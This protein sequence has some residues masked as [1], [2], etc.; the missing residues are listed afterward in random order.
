MGK[1]NKK[2]KLNRSID[3]ILSY[4]ISRN[5]KAGDKLPSE[6]Q[7]AA[8]AGVSRVSIREGMRGLKFLGLLDSAPRRGTLIREMD[9]SILS[10]CLSFQLASAPFLR[11]QLLEA[12]MALEL[13]VLELVCGRLD[14]GQL[15]A[16]R[17]IAD[18]ECRDDSASERERNLRLDNEFHRMLLEAGGNPILSAY[19]RMLEIFFTDIHTSSPRE[20]SRAAASEHHLLVDALEEGNL[21]L[22]R[23]LMRRHLGR[24]LTGEDVHAIC[25][26]AKK[27]KKTFLNKEEPGK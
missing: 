1:Y 4:I 27:R 12:R 5:L 7:L 22:A 8:L 20:G 15:A 11:R 19:T 18:C 24:Y 16:L 25:G 13:G 21:E 23:G 9:F 3:L 26:T 14:S 10:R 2:S 6:E 17:R